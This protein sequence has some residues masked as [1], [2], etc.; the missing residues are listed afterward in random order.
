LVTRIRKSKNGKHKGTTNSGISDQLRDIYN[1][2][3]NTWHKNRH[4]RKTTLYKENNA[5]QGK[6]RYSMKTTLFKEN[7]AAKQQTLLG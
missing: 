1:H 4:S 3:I 2:I 6:Q 5:I 7:N